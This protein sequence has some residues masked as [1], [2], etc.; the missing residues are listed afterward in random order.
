MNVRE[1]LL[2]FHA[3]WYSANMMGLAVCGVQ[4]LDTLEAMVVEKFSMVTN[5]NAD[6]GTISAHPFGQPQLGKVV[7]AVPVKEARHLIMTFPIPDQTHNFTSRPGHF[8][9]H[10]IGHEGAGSILSW[11]QEENLASSLSAGD[12]SGYP[13][14]FGFFIIS[15]DLT[16]KGLAHANEVVEIVFRYIAML[17]TEGPK[18]WVFD[19][20]KHINEIAFRFKDKERAAGYCSNLAGRLHVYP[21]EHLL[22]ASYVL[23]EFRPELITQLL[24]CLVPGQVRLMLVAKEFSALPNLCEE[25]VY[26]TLYVEEPIGVEQLQRWAAAERV[27]RL[28]LPAPNPFIAVNFDVLLPPPAPAQ[29]PVLLRDDPLIRLWYKQDTRFLMP[30]LNIFLAISSPLTYATP[31]S[32][33]MAEL[34]VHMLKVGRSNFYNTEH[35]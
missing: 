1:A 22:D 23:R 33:N 17:R 21:P 31:V 7:R 3:Q 27:E 28:H 9:S 12:S 20:L 15:V 14:G 10:L 4:P 11:L 29:F 6:P 34:F 19:E 35:L 18:S 30:K 16:E 25:P 24:D 13:G 2:D 8:L 26:G 5:I 32:S